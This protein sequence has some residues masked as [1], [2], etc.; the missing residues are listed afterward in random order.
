MLPFA[1]LSAKVCFSN[2]QVF[3]V[4]IVYVPKNRFCFS[5][6]FSAASICFFCVCGWK[7]TSL[8]MEDR[9]NMFG[10]CLNLNSIVGVG[11]VA[12]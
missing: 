2:A 10:V 6:F 9:L 7:L 12:G 5:H 8:D 3:L 11:D 4:H 1:F